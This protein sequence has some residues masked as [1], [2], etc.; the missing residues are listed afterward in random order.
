MLRAGCC[1]EVTERVD[2]KAEV[3]AALDEVVADREAIFA[4]NTSS[5]PIMKL[6][7]ATR[8]GP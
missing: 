6:A 8:R 3:L 4:S 2:A 5:I 7:M 1:R